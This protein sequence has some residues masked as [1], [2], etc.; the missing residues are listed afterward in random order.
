MLLQ[1][2]TP[3]STSS[4]VA[5]KL[6][7]SRRASFEG[8]E[9]RFPASRRA[10]N[11]PGGREGQS[12]FDSPSTARRAVTENGSSGKALPFVGPKEFRAFAVK[13][14]A[15]SDRAMQQHHQENGIRA[16]PMGRAAPKF[17]ARWSVQASG[18]F[19]HGRRAVNQIATTG[20]EGNMRSTEPN[21]S[22]VETRFPRAPARRLGGRC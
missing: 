20:P 5:G 2:D 11:G 3:E 12:G 17:G 21:E 19:R 8:L 6:G 14:P 13:A 16:L 18:A 22:L 9:A 7:R 1:G 15:G 10:Q 4:G